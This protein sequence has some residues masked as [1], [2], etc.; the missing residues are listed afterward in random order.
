MRFDLLNH[1][2]LVVGRA[3]LEG[4]IDGSTSADQD[5]KEVA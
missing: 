2:F 4:F 1:R 3:S 5:E